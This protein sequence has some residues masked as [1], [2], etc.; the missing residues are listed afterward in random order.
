MS[1]LKEEGGPGG[2]RGDVT[3]HAASAATPAYRTLSSK[4]EEESRA[5]SDI[6]IDTDNETASLL[7]SSVLSTIQEQPRTW[8]DRRLV[9]SYGPHHVV[10]PLEK[11]PVCG[12]DEKVEKGLRR[13]SLVW[14]QMT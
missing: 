5:R 13:I 8:P 10:L 11:A 6:D 1:R 9:V 7:H 12:L 2:G 4:A 14:R 3:V